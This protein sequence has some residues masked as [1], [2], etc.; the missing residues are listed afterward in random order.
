MYKYKKH[1]EIRTRF[2]KGNDP[3]QNILLWSVCNAIV[4]LVY[5]QICVSSLL[6][7]ILDLL[8]PLDDLKILPLAYN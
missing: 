1:N 4:I 6:L 3:L 5:H 2:I 7:T 8:S